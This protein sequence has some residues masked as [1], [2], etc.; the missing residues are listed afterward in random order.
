MARAPGSL[1]VD[2]ACDG[3][4]CPGEASRALGGA[5]V[6]A[7]S[8]AVLEREAEV[9][10]LR[11]QL[12]AARARSAGLEQLLGRTA[13]EA[14][15]FFG[16]SASLAKE[17]GRGRE[18]VEER[19]E[20]AVSEAV[21][22]MEGALLHLTEEIGGGEG[23]EG[24]RAGVPGEEPVGMPSAAAADLGADVAVPAPTQSGP[25]IAPSDPEGLDCQGHPDP[26][27]SDT[28]RPDVTL[29]GEDAPGFSGAVRAGLR[30]RGRFE[31][32]CAFARMD[33]KE[34]ALQ[35]KVSQMVQA[36]SGGG[37]SRGFWLEEGR[38]S[39]QGGS[40]AAIAS[41]DD[42]AAG[43]GVAR[44]V[45]RRGDLTLDPVGDS[46]ESRGLGDSEG[47]DGVDESYG[48]EG[49][50]GLASAG[51]AFDSPAR[52]N[53]DLKRATDTRSPSSP[54][55]GLGAS[56]SFSLIHSLTGSA[57][58][59][60]SSRAEDQ[61][62]CDPRER[63]QAAGLICSQ[64]SHAPGGFRCS[65]RS[66][67]SR[68]PCA[69]GAP[70]CFSN[71]QASPRQPSDPSDG[72]EDRPILFTSD[73]E[74]QGVIDEIHERILQSRVSAR[75]AER[76]LAAS[77][78]AGFTPAASVV[79]P[80]LPPPNASPGPERPLDDLVTERLRELREEVALSRS[81]RGELEQVV[82]KQGEE[83]A[84]ARERICE[85]EGELSRSRA[86]FPGASGGP[87]SD[88]SSVHT[89]EKPVLL[90][91]PDLPAVPSTLQR[92]DETERRYEELRVSYGEKSAALASLRAGE[93]SAGQ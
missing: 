49:P 81:Q 23:G 35:D 52:R 6:A 86:R 7:L 14:D 91:I 3:P 51:G 5:D 67:C 48:P 39:P 66:C 30:D 44:R 37:A 16:L 88:P 69:S 34:Q 1:A 62:A 89:P 31:L 32:D 33:L 22:T 45:G 20:G 93:G 57:R 73:D 4:A 75:E 10:E 25:A 79:A 59:L 80:A 87:G 41:A 65:C 92:A 54:G 19:V 40:G 82:Q 42:R 63:G 64:A 36:C 9:L 46:S 78:T 55:G 90:D 47:S 56:A 24:L 21:R 72:R 74:L 60:S 13:E 18:R 70:K 76:Q 12:D 8:R 28:S 17:L 68:S 26:E 53:S 11:R 29:P 61:G 84:R 38:A 83:L 15:R 58:R 2:A 77:T 85:L 71:G 27:P 43:N 50:G